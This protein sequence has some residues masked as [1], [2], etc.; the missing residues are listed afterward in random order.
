MNSN[1]KASILVRF[2]VGCLFLVLIYMFQPMSV[3]SAF[4]GFMASFIPEAYQGWKI[5]KT[6]GEYE[7]NK[8]LRLTYQSMISKWLMT[9]MIFALSFS[10]DIEWDYKILFAGYLLVSISGLLTP[11]FKGKK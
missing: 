11:I 1:I 5:S 9:A 2:V 8:W 7:P 3:F 4:I 10:S 6:E